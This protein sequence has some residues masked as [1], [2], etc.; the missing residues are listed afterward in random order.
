MVWLHQRNALPTTVATRARTIALVAQASPKSPCDATAV[1]TRATNVHPPGHVVRGALHI[2]RALARAHAPVTTA[3][4]QICRAQRACR[5]Q[6]RV[7]AVARHTRRARMRIRARA[8][9]GISSTLIAM[10]VLRAVRP[11]PRGTSSPSG[12]AAATPS[13]TRTPPCR[14]R[15]QLVAPTR[16]A[17]ASTTRAATTAGAFTS[18]TRRRCK[19][20]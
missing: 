11:P 14:P 20:L 15:R 7:A 17:L 4:K 9:A 5:P 10:A 6:L 19:R 8:T 13:G 2:L 3:M 16:S 18:A 1:S 12:T